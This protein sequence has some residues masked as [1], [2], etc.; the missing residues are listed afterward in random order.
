ME[1]CGNARRLEATPV[2]EFVDLLAT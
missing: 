1:L 2:N